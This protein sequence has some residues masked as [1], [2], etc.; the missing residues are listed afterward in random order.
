MGHG[1]IVVLCMSPGRADIVVFLLYIGS[2][3]VTDFDQSVVVYGV[4]VI[5]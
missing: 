1:G 5:C 3:F 2:I 4:G